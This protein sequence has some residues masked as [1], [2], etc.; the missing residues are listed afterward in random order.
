MYNYIGPT[1]LSLS[2]TIAN[3][4]KPTTHNLEK[5]TTT[6]NKRHGA[7]TNHQPTT[8]TTTRLCVCAS[9]CPYLRRAR[10]PRR[11]PLGTGYVLHFTNSMRHPWLYVYAMLY[12]ELIFVIHVL[13]QGAR[14]W[15]LLARLRMLAL[16]EYI[17]NVYEAPP[18]GFRGDCGRPDRLS[19]LH[20]PRWRAGDRKDG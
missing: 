16:Y 18:N 4:K 10:A 2:P 17:Y 11:W 5:K 14:W 13:A 6:D 12:Q 19:R 3:K 7:L 20:T 9:L 15:R 1:P 8:T